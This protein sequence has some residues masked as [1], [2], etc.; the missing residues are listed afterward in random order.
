[1]NFQAW[2]PG[3]GV[4]VAV[5]VSVGVPVGDAVGLGVGEAVCVG[6]SV[7]LG[8]GVAVA[9]TRVGVAVRVGEGGTVGVPVGVDVGAEVGDGGTDMDVAVCDTG[10][11][12]GVVRAMEPGVGLAMS[13]G[14]A[15]ATS[16]SVTESSPL[17][18]LNV[19]TVAAMKPM[20]RN[21]LP[22][23]PLESRVSSMGRLL[24][25]AGAPRMSAR[26]GGC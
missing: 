8:D 2:V 16:V 19:T 11:G 22:A 9:G 23:M 13:I 1:M 10:D 26:R 20:A 18:A 21:R 6:T 4:G 25:T 17:H 5:G 12:V 15:W 3:P 7:G 24:S 14:A